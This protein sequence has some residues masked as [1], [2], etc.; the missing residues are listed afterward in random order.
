MV[1]DVH[2]ASQLYFPHE[3][4]QVHDPIVDLV[5]L[6]LDPEQEQKTLGLHVLV[7]PLPW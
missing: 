5:F 2:L 7:L 3:E 6:F 1:F 4:A